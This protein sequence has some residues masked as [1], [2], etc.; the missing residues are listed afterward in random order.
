[1]PLPELDT[2]APGEDEDPPAGLAVVGYRLVV[3]V[4]C[5]DWEV[6]DLMLMEQW[7]VRL[8]LWGFE[9]LDELME[10]LSAQKAAVSLPMVLLGLELE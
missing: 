10:P 3:V 4:N 7:L 5:P 6:E 9:S 8:Q 2:A 1:M